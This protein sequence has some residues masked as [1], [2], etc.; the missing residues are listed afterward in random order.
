MATEKQIEEAILRVAGNPSSGSIKALAAEMAQAVADLD[1]P[2]REKPKPQ[3]EVRIEG[4][5][6]TR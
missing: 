6:E 5:V 4:P 2:K 1:A 3:R